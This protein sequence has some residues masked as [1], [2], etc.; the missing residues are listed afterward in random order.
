LAEK[1]LNG[2]RVS[3][4][5]GICRCRRFDRGNSHLAHGKKLSQIVV[6]LRCD[7]LSL[8]CLGLTESF[9]QGSQL[10]MRFRQRRR[11]LRD[12]A[13]KKFIERF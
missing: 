9:D 3:R 13:L 1:F 2:E 12:P 5:R 8:M 11:P 6:Q 4:D 7:A 10:L